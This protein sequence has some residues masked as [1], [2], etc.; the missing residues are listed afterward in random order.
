MDVSSH[1]CGYMDVCYEF[2]KNFGV[3]KRVEL[4]E[5]LAT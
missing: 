3:K 1:R 5:L 4:K 2:F